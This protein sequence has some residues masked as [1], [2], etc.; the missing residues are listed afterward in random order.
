MTDSQTDPYG[1]DGKVFSIENVANNR[2]LDIELNDLNRNGTLVIASEKVK[3]GLSSQQWKF[4]ATGKGDKFYYILNQDK[5]VG[6][7]NYLE[8][9]PYDIGKNNGK[10]RLW[11]F[12][13]TLR[14]KDGANQVWYVNQHNNNQY[15]IISKAHG[16]FALSINQNEIEEHR[17]RMVIL[18]HSENKLSMYW[19]LTEIR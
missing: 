12:N 3:G 17:D 1:L 13:E 18:N 2:V 5:K 7:H 19:I 11:E 9:N 4:V 10:V 16:A 6:H 15:R 14:N 8:V